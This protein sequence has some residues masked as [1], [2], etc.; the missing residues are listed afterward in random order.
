[1]TA[2]RREDVADC[3]TRMGRKHSPYH[4]A[5]APTHILAKAKGPFYVAER[6]MRFTW[7]RQL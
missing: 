5:R 3:D 7:E 6:P 2:Y 1:M 4:L